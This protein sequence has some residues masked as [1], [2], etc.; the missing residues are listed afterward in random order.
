MDSLKAW[1]A[2]QIRDSL[3]PSIN[4]LVRLKKRMEE[5]GFLPTDPLLTLVTKAY[6]AI[7]ALYSEMN[8]QSCKSGAGREP[9][10]E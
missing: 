10:E 3:F 8:Y 2:E 5:T 9:N 7:H 1:Q 6:D 4:Y